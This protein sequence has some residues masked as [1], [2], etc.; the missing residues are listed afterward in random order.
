MGLR[1]GRNPQNKFEYRNDILTG[2][3]REYKAIAEINGVA[4][5]RVTR[6]GIVAGE[7]VQPINVWV[8]GEQDVPGV[9]PVPLD[10][11]QMAWLTNGVGR[12]AGGNLWGPINPFPQSGVFIDPPVCPNTSA[13]AF[14]G[15]TNSTTSSE[16]SSL[17]KRGSVGRWSSRARLEAKADA[18]NKGTTDPPLMRIAPQPKRVD[19]SSH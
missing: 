5:T 4:K 11:S 3:A 13:T 12:D 10:F 2:Y 14:Q 18:E 7:Y 9:P 8:P 1:G 6:N 16:T 17:N 15:S 19:L